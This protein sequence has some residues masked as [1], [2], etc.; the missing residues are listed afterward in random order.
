M[1]KK[2]QNW[3]SESQSI[4]TMQDYL[5]FDRDSSYWEL[6]PYFSDHVDPSLYYIIFSS[7]YY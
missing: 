4:S 2:T 3:Q 7:W 5:K 6:S 1:S